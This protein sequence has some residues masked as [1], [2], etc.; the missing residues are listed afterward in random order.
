MLEGNLTARRYIS[1]VLEEHVVPFF[2]QHDDLRMFQHDNARPHSAGITSDYLHAEGVTVLPWPAFS[3]DLSPIEHLWD[4]IGRRV[5][6]RDNPPRTRQQLVNALTEEWNLIPQR[7][8]QT[9][10]RSM[11]QRCQATIAARGGHTRY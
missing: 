5:A 3:P 7:N 10:I 8:I 9:L 11:R 4:Q 6:Q 1:D 2:E